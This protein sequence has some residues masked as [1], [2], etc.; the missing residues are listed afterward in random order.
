M[1]NELADAPS[2]QDDLECSQAGKTEVTPIS[3]NP[4]EMLA[5]RKPRQAVR[6]VKLSHPESHLAPDFL[7]K[8]TQFAGSSKRKIQDDEDPSSSHAPPARKPRLEVPHSPTDSRPRDG[9]FKQPLSPSNSL[10]QDSPSSSGDS[11]TPQLPPFNV[12][13]G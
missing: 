3:L 13:R 8:N 4:S 5:P 9:L 10:Y 11:S 12:N 7:L 2:C 1:F 6:K